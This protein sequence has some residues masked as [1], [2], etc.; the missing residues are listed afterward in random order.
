MLEV[1]GAIPAGNESLYSEVVLTNHDC[2][3]EPCRL[4]IGLNR[5]VS[6]AEC[7]TA[8]RTGL[9]RYKASHR[10]AVLS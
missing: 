2:R 3:I 7:R 1:I 9:Q 8:M 10:T 6:E 4:M 5:N